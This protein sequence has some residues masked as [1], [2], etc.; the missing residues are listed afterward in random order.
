M[1]SEKRKGKLINASK[2]IVERNGE[3]VQYSKESEYKGIKT[4]Y[5][6]HTLEFDNGDKGTARTKKPEGNFNIGHNYSYA[7]REF[8]NGNYTN[9]S[10]SYLQDLDRPSYQGKSF[11]PEQQKEILNQVAFIAANSVVNSVEEDYMDVYK[12]FRSWLYEQVIDK[13][14]NSQSMSGVIKIAASYF[15]EKK[16][17]S[18]SVIKFAN[19]L[20]E[21]IKDTSWESQTNTQ[22]SSETPKQKAQQNQSNTPKSPLTPPENMTN[23]LPF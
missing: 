23:D 14:E 6:Y 2:L 7:K 18:Q 9:I 16:T 8:Q 11:N 19:K 22:N 21:K 13:K 1:E 12:A 15:S 4:L 5:Y 20:I 10:F 17:S 3:N